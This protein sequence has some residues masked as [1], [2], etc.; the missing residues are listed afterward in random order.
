MIDTSLNV[1]AT[2]CWDR[3]L[4]DVKIKSTKLKRAGDSSV[5]PDIILSKSSDFRR[6]ATLGEG[7]PEIGA[8]GFSGNAIRYERMRL[9][10][11]GCSSVSSITLT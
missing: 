2:V 3:D 10:M 7:G 6:R 11:S 4:R 9:M 5:G 1:A 8:E